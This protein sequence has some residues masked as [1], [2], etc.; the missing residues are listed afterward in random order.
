MCHDAP[1]PPTLA[2]VAG[3]GVDV[4]YWCNR[5]SHH[6]VLPVA[7]LIAHLGLT[8][9]AA[10]VT[11][12]ATAMMTV[13]TAATATAMTAATAMMA[14]ETATTVTAVVTGGQVK[15]AT[16]AAPAAV[17]ALAAATLRAPVTTYGRGNRTGYLIFSRAREQQLRPTSGAEG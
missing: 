13:V 6:A 4:F 17:L 12:A 7:V 14:V 1:F 11:M 5:C 15:V 16:V 3:Y 2:Q 9:P 10:M 8:L